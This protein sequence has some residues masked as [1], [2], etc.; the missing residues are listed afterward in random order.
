MKP[1]S[2]LVSPL[3]SN[4]F[5][6]GNKRAAAIVFIFDPDDMSRLPEDPI[7]GMFGL[8]PAESR[9]AALIAAGKSVRECSTRLRLTEGTV[10][11]YL[12]SIFRKT[13]STSQSELVN[14]ILRSPLIFE[15]DN[16]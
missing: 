2:V 8:T 11:Q 14:L 13:D 7:A 3:R 5:N 1:Y 15:S 10:R 4:H 6:L 16:R 12:K 9:L